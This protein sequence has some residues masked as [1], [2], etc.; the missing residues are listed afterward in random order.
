MAMTSAATT[1][2]AATVA[3]SPG[4]ISADNQ[5]P[6]GGAKGAGAAATTPSRA[7][8]RISGSTASA[9]PTQCG[10]TAQPSRRPPGLV[11]SVH[12]PLG[13][14][15]GVRRWAVRVGGPVAI[16][17]VAATALRSHLPDAGSLL[18]ALRH[19]DP[20]WLI[21]AAAAQA[22]S[23]AMFARQHTT[24]LRGFH[25]PLSNRR[26]LAITY[27]STA[28]SVT[29]P[30][31]GLLAA[32]FTFAQWRSWGAT[33][34]IGA[35]VTVLSGI[36]SF[37]GLAGLYLVGSGA[38]LAVHPQSL[39]AIGTPALLSIAGILAA[40]ALL[41]ARRRARPARPPRRR[42]VK[43]AMRPQWINRLTSSA[44]QLWRAAGA[45]PW[46]YTVAALAF[47]A[48]NWLTDLLCLV[49]TGRA[50]H[51][52]LG[53]LPLAGVY[54]AVQIVR[55]APLTPGG[56]GLIEA[57]L[58]AGLAAA[59]AAQSDAAAVVI[60]YRVLSCWLIL[61]IGAL[62]W[63]VLHRHNDATATRYPPAVPATVG[64]PAAHDG[65]PSN[66]PVVS[67]TPGRPRGRGGPPG[68]PRGSGRRFRLRCAKLRQR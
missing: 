58:L 47:A 18:H 54:L 19:A 26:S 46:R 60:I 5:R 64:G 21:L 50:L 37:L 36:V 25:I 66:P 22:V 52:R 49:L 44:R 1:P 40:L 62:S 29:M 38:A 53:L 35:T 20:V 15:H 55:Q 33:R 13:T 8:N 63:S 6:G 57:S 51:L 11:P 9:R 27:A 59:G 14:P 28:I 39:R 42:A 41:A 10:A 24:L 56:V 30:A 67:V 16:V 34:T 45:L 32:G 3:C 61:P 12:T 43:P 48:T 4:W 68:R 65:E 7:K 23:I 2:R 17:A 31:G